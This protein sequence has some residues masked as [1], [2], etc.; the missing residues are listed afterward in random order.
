MNQIDFL[1]S[2]ATFLDLDLPKDAALDSRDTIDVFLGNSDQSLPYML[3]EAPNALAIR[4][5]QWKYI[6]F[7]ASKYRPNPGPAE[8]YDLSADIAEVNNVIA[9]HPQVAKSLCK[10]LRTIQASS[11]IC[12]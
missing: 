7:H 11:R 3:E 12:K 4:K 1:Q 9:E 5:D 10:Q 2:F 8:L 6:E